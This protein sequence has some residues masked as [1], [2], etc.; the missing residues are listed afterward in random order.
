MLL[1]L[2]RITFYM[3][4]CYTSLVASKARSREKLKHKVEC[5]SELHYEISTLGDKYDKVQRD[6]S[7]F[8][9]KNRELPS[10]SDASSEELRKLKVQFAEA[11]ATAARLSD[12]LYRD[13]AIDAEDRLNS[14]RGEV[15]D[16]VGSGVESLFY[17]LLSNDE[18]NSALARVAYLGI[19]SGVERGL[20]M[21][22]TNVG[23]EE[24]AQNVSNF[25]VGVEAEFNKAVVDLL[26]IKF[27][28]LSKIAEA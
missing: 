12:E 25:F 4:S 11:E 26:S 15:T 17:R 27:P 2:R 22:R 19:T 10:F 14:L 20:R 18:F 28:F 6:W 13:A 3:N 21:G 23:F 16:F 5:I 24:A 9:Q 7:L 1:M 8:Y